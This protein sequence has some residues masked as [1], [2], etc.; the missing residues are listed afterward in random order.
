MRHFSTILLAVT[1]SVAPGCGDDGNGESSSA[2]GSASGSESTAATASASMSST[3]SPT[4]A[5]TGTGCDPALDANPEHICC[6]GA[7]VDPRSDLFHCG[8]CGTA[9]ADP[10]P[11]CDQGTCAAVPCSDQACTDA[12]SCCGL[13]CCGSDSI[14]CTLNGPVES[15]PGCVPIAEVANCPAG[16]APLCKCAAPDTLIATPAG[17]RPIAALRRGDLV[18]S[19]DDGETTVVPIARVQ[20]VPVRDHDVARAVLDDGRTL[21]ITPSHPLADGRAFGDVRVG[22]RLGDAVVVAF[23]IVAY[24]EPFTHDIL[25]MSSSGAY[26]VA[27]ELIASTMIASE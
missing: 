12:E 26:F 3:S 22:E 6:D 18:Y 23:E 8:G 5:D 21:R 20:R 7:W 25:P 1:A 19:V 17:E 16:C 27:G 24:D 11:F 10:T 2:S 9:C 4:S 13:T 14:C 15:G